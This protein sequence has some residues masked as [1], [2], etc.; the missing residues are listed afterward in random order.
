MKHH[1]VIAT[2]VLVAAPLAVA[3]EEP[4]DSSDW[5]RCQAYHAS[6]EG[7][8]SS[9]GSAHDNPGFAGI[10]SSC[11]EETSPPYEG[12]PAEDHAGENPGQNADDGADNAPDDPGSQA[13]D[14]PG[15]EGDEGDDRQPDDPGSQQPNVFLP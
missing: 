4:D 5:G 10:N 15:D 7:N 3:A 8:E 1:V 14:N 11:D 6:E 2:L 12:T 9:N 13:P